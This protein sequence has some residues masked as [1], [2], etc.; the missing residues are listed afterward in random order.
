MGISDI[1]NI[2][3]L[4]EE[5][6]QLHNLLTPE[7]QNALNLQNYINQLQTQINDLQKKKNIIDAPEIGSTRT[8]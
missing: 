7:M 1:F 3:H 8:R 5:N 6:E 4:K 2:K